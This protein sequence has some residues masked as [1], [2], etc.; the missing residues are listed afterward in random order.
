MRIFLIILIFFIQN[1]AHSEEVKWNDSGF[2]TTDKYIQSYRK[3]F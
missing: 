3:G 1:F 2:N